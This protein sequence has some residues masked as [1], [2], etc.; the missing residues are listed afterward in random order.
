MKTKELSVKQMNSVR[1]TTCGAATG[2][3][4]ELHSGALRLEPHR[5]RKL[6][7]A[8]A[9]EAKRNKRQAAI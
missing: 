7:A 2:E 4:C 3:P 6:S 1:C 5:E 9:L 8:D